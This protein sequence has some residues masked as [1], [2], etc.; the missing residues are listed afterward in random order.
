MCL[1]ENLDKPLIRLQALGSC[2]FARLSVLVS[3]LSCRSIVQIYTPT[4]LQTFSDLNLK[5]NTFNFHLLIILYIGWRKMFF[6]FIA[7][8]Y[9]YPFGS[10]ISG[11]NYLGVYSQ[12]VFI[13]NTR[14]K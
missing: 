14:R 7:F 12:G 4:E 13:N 5:N 1:E 9:F 2:I 6:V 8:E 10:W 11:K 3:E